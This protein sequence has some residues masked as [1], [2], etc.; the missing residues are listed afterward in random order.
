MIHVAA[1]AT[2]GV[3]I[4]DRRQTRE[5][6]ISTFKQQLTALRDKLNVRKVPALSL[7][8]F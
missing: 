1:R 2:N 3:K 6:I 4:P 7:L 8:S 5:A